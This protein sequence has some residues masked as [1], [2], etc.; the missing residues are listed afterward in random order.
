MWGSGAGWWLRAEWGGS[1]H[2]PLLAADVMLLHRVAK[3][4]GPGARDDSWLPGVHVEG[5]RE[6]WAGRRGEGSRGVSQVEVCTPEVWGA[7]GRSPTLDSLGGVCSVI[8]GP[9]LEEPTI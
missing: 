7:H 4:G 2:S 5:V 1:F 3:E 8:L 9:C 6:P